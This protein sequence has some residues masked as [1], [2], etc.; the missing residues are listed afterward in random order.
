MVR[1]IACCLGIMATAAWVSA[2][3]A[4][5]RKF[6]VPADLAEKSLRVFSVQSGSEVLFS[7]D[8]ASG[9]RTNA[10]SGEFLPGEAVKKMLAGTTLYVRDERDG[11]FRIAATPRPKAPGAALNPGPNDRPGEAKSGARSRDAPPGT[12]STAQP[13]PLQTSPP[14]HN[15]S[16][17]V[18]N[19]NLFSFLA[20]W[21]AVGTA[22]DA[23]TANTSTVPGRDQVVELSPFEVST[24]KDTSYGA[25]NSNSIS[26]FNMNLL[27]TPVAADIF[28]E[29][30][31]R[32]MATTNLEDL[33]SG[34]GAGYGMLNQSPENANDNQ[35]GDRGGFGFGSRGVA[36]GA[37]RRDGFVKTAVNPNLNDSFDTERVEIIKG[38]NAMLFGAS[39]A[40]GIVNT[41]SKRAQ[42]ST[43]ARPL[44]TS[45][46]SMRIDQYGSKR[47]ML[48]TNYG[49][50]KLA[51][52]FVLLDDKQNYRRLY[53][54]HKTDA[55][56]AAIAARLPF[57]SILRVTARKTDND[58]ITP[59]T[60]ND[61]S[62]TNATR[63]PRHLF[64][65]PY[66]LATDQAGAINPKTGIAYPAGAILN[67][68]LTW[69]NAY[70]IGGSTNEED[71]ST[72]S[73]GVSFDTIWAKWLSTSLAGMYDCGTQQRTLAGSLLAPKSFNSAN[74]LEE[75]AY[76]T[77]MAMAR[78]NTSNSGR[79]HAYRANA[80]VTN[81][82]F[83]GKARSQTVVGYDLSFT[84]SGVVHY[85]Y[86]EAD[87]NFR[88]FDLNNPRPA[89]PGNVIAPNQLGRYALPVTYWSVANGLVKDP[90]FRSGSRQVTVNGK[91]YVLLQQN[92]RNPNFVG[93]LNPLGLV[94]LVPGFTGVGGSNTGNYANYGKD[95]GIYGANYTSWFDDRLTTLFGYRF[96]KTFGR[97]PNTV[98]TGTQPY[99]ES[100][101][102]NRSYNA[103][104]NYRLKSWL[105]AYY[106]IGQT[107]LPGSSNG[108]A[109]GELP[110]N[111]AGSSEEIGFKYESRDARFSGSFSYYQA[112]S[113]NEAFNYG[114]AYRDLVNPIGL[115]DAFNA[116]MR[117]SWLALD[118]K[119]SGLEII[120]TA[121]PTRNWR[122]RL[123]FT[124]QDGT[125]NTSK[126]FAM[127][128][129][130]EFFYN[131][132]TG[133][134]T[135][136]DGTPFM[137]PTDTAGRAAVNGTSTLRAPVEGTTNS[138]LT[139][140]M[141]NDPT[142]PYYAYGQGGT[143][144]PNGRIAPNSLVFRAL[145]WF[146]IPS[147]GQNIQ[148]RTLRTGLPLSAIPYAFN[149]PAGYNGV[150]EMS[151]AGEPTIG[152][153]LYRIVLTNT[154]DFREGWLRGTTIGGTLRW[155]IDKRAYW[156]TEPTSSG[157]FI[158]YLLKE[159]NI[160]PQMNPFISYRRKI[161]RYTFGTQLNVNN[162]FNKYK[163]EIRPA[164][165]TGYTVENA[166]TATFV[167]EPRQFVWTNTIGF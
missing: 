10:I 9:V 106:N 93:P 82:L 79:R 141:M 145:R 22:A 117:N 34:Y 157:G 130:D 99:T 116:S 63:D 26:A 114:I 163:V 104:F 90:L 46:L 160:N 71:I 108:D 124:Q 64:S 36:A 78:N 38:A 69:G 132:A 41:G 155:D 136:A 50:E 25:L 128:W 94:S 32:D 18:K 88:A 95:Y 133:G 56:Y 156:Y 131:K 12:S 45:S 54:G 42:F 19:R 2:G 77:N 107:Y 13:N 20:A 164:S 158:R 49:L 144:Q 115:N 120:M 111:V 109:Y 159:A 92:P 146:Q 98:L 31:M 119:S 21:L 105:Y 68:K 16:P 11:V 59:G 85:Q 1:A 5:K 122:A 147:G 118:K 29:E 40:G 110:G 57:D 76:G 74:P 37:T 39:G 61:V 33:L 3:E 167:G 67:G 72:E 80:L 97:G 140:A 14:K 137:V 151:V 81:E 75:W 123:G 17:P 153:P 65:L 101:R 6:D 30:F 83:K 149:D 70:S 134:V 84:G 143:V 15:E 161:G 100:S 135:Y 150:A 162:V 8:A 96:S 89:I 48:D 47:V 154:I 148:A 126:S 91:N 44:S 23:Q 43:G 112:R 166:L 4:E 55:F 58:R 24:S 35:P 139:I 66:L 152:H 138:Q 86:F 7:S 51:F 28:T 73:V 121:A 113:K 165:A 87:S 129:N 53:I 52:R 60:V 102:D 103:G 27:K 62:F 125:I 127:L 142:N